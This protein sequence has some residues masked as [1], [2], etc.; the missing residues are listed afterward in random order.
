MIRIGDTWYGTHIDHNIPKTEANTTNEYT[1]GQI[2]FPDLIAIEPNDDIHESRT[3]DELKQAC[4]DGIDQIFG[5][6]I[7]G[8]ILSN[9]DEFRPEQMVFPDHI[10]H[11]PIEIIHNEYIIANEMNSVED[12]VST[13][14]KFEENT[15]RRIPTKH[16]M[17]PNHQSVLKFKP[18]ECASCDKSY[19]DSRN[20]I[21]HVNKYNHI[22]K[23]SNLEVSKKS[24]R[25][26]GKTYIPTKTRIWTWKCEYC[27]MNFEF[28]TDLAQHTS[29][30]HN[31]TYSLKIVNNTDTK[32]NDLTESDS[33]D[34]SNQRN[35]TAE[36]ESEGRE[37]D[38]KGGKKDTRR[39]CEICNKKF[40]CPTGLKYHMNLHLQVKPFVCDQCDKAFS[41][42]RNLNEHKKLHIPITHTLDDY[43]EVN[44]IVVQLT[45]EQLETL[46]CP[47]CNKKFC[48]K[49]GLRC[50]VRVHENPKYKC[51]ICEKEFIDK[52]AYQRHRSISHLNP[53]ENVA[54][55]NLNIKDYA[56]VTES[57]IA[58]DW[59]CE[60]CNGDFEFEIR[61][62]KHIIKEHHHNKHEHLCNICD[63]KFKQLNELLTHMRAHPESNQ[64]KCT[65]DY[66]SQSFAYKSSL[67]LHTNKHMRLKGP[68]E[69][70]TQDHLTQITKQHALFNSS[71]DKS[72]NLDENLFICGTCNKKCSNRTSFLSHIQGVHS[73]IR[74]KCPV[75]SCDKI[76]KTENGISSHVQN[77]HPEA[78]KECGICG[79]TFC[80]DEKLAKHQLRHSKSKNVSFMCG[81]CLK[82]F[83]TKHDLR[84]HL[85]HHEK[86][87]I[88]NV[89][90]EKFSSVK[91]MMQHR[92]RHGKKSIITCRFKGC[93]AVF[94]NRKEFSLH[95][96]QHPDSEKKKF[97]CSYCG[98]FMS[99]LSY[100]KDHMNTH[101]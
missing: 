14:D 89:C 8:N 32:K 74:I 15:K 41:D 77:V 40:L 51:K 36:M 85:S 84:V 45:K 25:T 11:K 54:S 44:G 42:K 56:D 3:Q 2:V 47:V 9:N 75:F 92:E 76:F 70:K 4:T 87:A 55:E 23:N 28:E 12:D 35:T 30:Q 65:F 83:G 101:R 5:S 20:L 72:S 94:E 81:I 61:L 97:I 59:I 10:E 22:F 88:C 64:Y 38:L 27:H 24:T 53:G 17:N 31:N 46:E 71:S 26:S 60:Y 67:S 66:C 58:V 50:H 73:L 19:A 1:K 80:S 13:S 49:T 52:E 96:S 7:D 90:G 16:D 98:K 93:N 34:Q 82:K 86:D 33:D 79:K 43:L 100:L 62:A 99:S 95:A 37:I 21:I 57:S 18:Y 39:V 91:Q 78:M 68:I 48:N 63:G 69:R 29:L 6:T